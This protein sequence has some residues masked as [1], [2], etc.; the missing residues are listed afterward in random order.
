MGGWGWDEAL[1]TERDLRL[2]ENLRRAYDRVTELFE[3]AAVEG[4]A[5]VATPDV[6]CDLHAIIMAG[7]PGAG[8]VRREDVQV[9]RAYALFSPPPWQEVDGHLVDASVYIQR[10]L[11]Q[12]TPLH[13]GAYALW[14]FNWIHPFG[15]GNGRTARAITYGILCA[16]FGRMFPGELTIDEQISYNKFP[17]WDALKAADRAWSDG[18]VDV[19][20]MEALLD[21]LLERQMSAR[22]SGVP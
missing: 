18:V 16:G 2:K 8:T 15:D 17:Y 7:E 6:L 11:A 22:P 1:P 14:R 9:G 3:R 5:C 21:D 13:A 4:A 12:D 20:E 19:S 10:A